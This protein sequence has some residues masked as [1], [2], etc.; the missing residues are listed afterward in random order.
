MAH[1]PEPEQSQKEITARLRDLKDGPQDLLSAA[2]AIFTALDPENQERLRGPSLFTI[3]PEK[4]G[5][6]SNKVRLICWR[7][8]PGGPHPGSPIGSN[9]APDYVL[10]F[11]KDWLLKA[12]PYVS[13]VVTLLKAFMPLA[14]DVAGQI[15]A[16]APG[17]DIKDAIAAM[18]DMATALPAGKLEVG[19]AHDTDFSLGRR[20]HDEHG[21][22][23][24]PELVALGHIHDLLEGHI[25][26]DQR[27][28]TLRPV[29][30]KTG[31]ILWLCAQHA[32]I[33]SPPPQR[34]EMAFLIRLSVD[35]HVSD[36]E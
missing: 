13:W 5:L 31:D 6:T 21:F 7:E 32:A 30:T 14:G 28:G 24:R 26:K 20:W 9:Q 16:S 12:A 27:W 36:V 18:K 17:M 34:F 3:L 8:H 10:K 15:A 25:P 11:P 1:E 4:D 35:L 22:H 33:Q 19:T 29:R 23:D 2:Y